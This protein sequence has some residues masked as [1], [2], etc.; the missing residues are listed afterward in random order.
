M[1]SPQ[2]IARLVGHHSPEQEEGSSG[3]VA[4]PFDPAAVALAASDICARLVNASYALA[5]D[6]EDIVLEAAAEIDRLRI[7]LRAVRACTDD[8]WRAQIVKDALREEQ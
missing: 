3:A 8:S 5:N 2:E 7:A 6:D 1:T 4:P